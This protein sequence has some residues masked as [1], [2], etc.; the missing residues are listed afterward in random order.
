MSDF[1]YLSHGGPGSGRYPLGSGDR[2]YQKYE[3]SGGRGI[4]RLSGYIRSVREK[5]AEKQ[6][7]KTRNEELR[8]ALEAEQLT[9]QKELDKERV[10]RSGTATEVLKYQGELS[11]QELQNAVTRI[12]LESQLRGMSQKEMKSAMDKVDNIMKNVKTA[13]EWAKIGT[14]TYNTFAK[15][16][17]ATPEGQEKP[18]TLVGGKRKKNQNND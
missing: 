15:I 16:Y 8:K 13:N 1:Y 18:L 4:G 3:G 17:N 2:P 7:Q 10:L 14:D 12:N 11:N 6:Q 5:H 9:R